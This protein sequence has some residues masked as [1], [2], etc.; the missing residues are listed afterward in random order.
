VVY[1]CSFALFSLFPF[2]FVF[3]CVALTRVLLLT[4]VCVL[5]PFVTCTAFVARTYNPKPFL[6]SCPPDLSLFQ[7]FKLL[8]TFS[9]LSCAKSLRFLSPMF[10]SMHTLFNIQFWFPFIS[11]LCSIRRTRFLCRCFVMS[12]LLMS[13]F[14]AQAPTHLTLLLSSLERR[15]PPRQAPVSLRFEQGSSQESLKHWNGCSLVVSHSISLYFPR[16]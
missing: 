2:V 6:P 14:Q 5:H 15:C 9:I 10:R 4:L 1:N 13:I 16:Q 11:F 12:K 3:S 8:F 7:T